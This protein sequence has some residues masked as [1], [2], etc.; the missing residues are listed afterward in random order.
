MTSTLDPNTDLAD[1]VRQLVDKVGELL[2]QG[3]AVIPIVGALEVSVRKYRRALWA[4][5]AIGT[6]LVLVLAAVALD[7]RSQ[8]AALKRQ[9]CPVVQASLT[10]APPSTQHGIDVE[11]AMRK[12]AGKFHCSN[13]R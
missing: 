6:A 13:I 7:N 4:A 3:S 12:L 10:G 8:V 1:A 5:V 11:E 2:E 9:F